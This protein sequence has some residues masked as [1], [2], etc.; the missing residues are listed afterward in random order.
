MAWPARRHRRFSSLC[1]SR[2]VL[3]CLATGATSLLVQT[4]LMRAIVASGS[5]CSGARFSRSGVDRSAAVLGAIGLL[6]NGLGCVVDVPGSQEA[7]K[8]A[9]AGDNR[10]HDGG[11][12]FPILFRPFAAVGRED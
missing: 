8:L 3:R 1:A 6:G 11:V 10:A 2:S 5:T 9:I 4:V 7:G 12:L